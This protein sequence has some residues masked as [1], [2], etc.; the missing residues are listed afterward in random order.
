MLLWN[1]LWL[2]KNAIKMRCKYAQY[3]R[4]RGAK[5]QSW[6]SWPF[7]WEKPRCTLPLW[8]RRESRRR[9]R[10]QN[11]RRYAMTSSQ[12]LA[13][14]QC[15]IHMILV[16]SYTMLVCFCLVIRF[17]HFFP[18]INDCISCLKEGYLT[19]SISWSLSSLSLIKPCQRHNES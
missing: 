15:F 1:W 10:M 14:A 13:E 7:C 3:S 2:I 8:R 17:V 4:W 11:F 12:S 5:Q 16:S 19:L 6:R 18:T 9:Q